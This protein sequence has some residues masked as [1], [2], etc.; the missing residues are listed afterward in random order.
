MRLRQT[1]KSARLLETPF[2]HQ[3][4]W[5]GSRHR[6]FQLDSHLRTELEPGLIY[7]DSATCFYSFAPARIQERRPTEILYV[8]PG[9]GFGYIWQQ[10]HVVDAPY[11]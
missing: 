1:Q 8:T 9:I 11:D 6:E 7:A 5:N 10:V 2:Q 3:G 4:F